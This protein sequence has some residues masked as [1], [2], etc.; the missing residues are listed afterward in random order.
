MQPNPWDDGE[1][2]PNQ[3]SNQESAV[4]GDFNSGDVNHNQSEQSS[5]YQSQ[6]PPPSQVLVGFP[7]QMNMPM[8]QQV[9]FLQPKPSSP[10][11]IGIVLVIVGALSSLGLL[12]LLDPVDP[13]TYEKIPLTALTAMTLNTLATTGGYILAGVWMTQYKKNGIYLA[14]A[15][16]LVSYILGLAGVALGGPNG[17]LDVFFEDDEVLGIT[18]FVDGICSVICGLIIAIPLLSGGNNGLE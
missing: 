14:L 6:Q 12:T 10:K 18:A 15:V 3:V 1:Y 2:T 5:P 13:V 9:V 7:Q 4:A 16:T 11:V 8:G 17:G